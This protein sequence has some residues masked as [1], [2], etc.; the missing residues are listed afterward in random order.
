[1]VLSECRQNVTDGGAD[2]TASAV[3]AAAFR[4]MFE[5]GKSL[6]DWVQVGRV[7]WQEEKLGAD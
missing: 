3:W 2:G 5:V 4:S 7:L 1:M 6:F